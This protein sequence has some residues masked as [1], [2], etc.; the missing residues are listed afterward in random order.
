[1]HKLLLTTA[2]LAVMNTPG[3]AELLT[4]TITDD[5]ALVDTVSSA[6]GAISWTTSDTNF[7][8]ISG[9]ASGSPLLP[10][11]D[12][13]STALNVRDTA[14]G[15]HTLVIDIT[16]TGVSGNGPTESSFTANNLIGAAN[17][18]TTEETLANGSMLAT[19][20]FPV[21]TVSGHFGP[22]SVPFGAISSDEHTYT[23]TF[24]GAGSS[25]DTIQLNTNAPVATIP[26]TSTWAM[27][28]IGFGFLA[29]GALSRR[30]FNSLM[31]A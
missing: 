24:T 14:G 28:M 11:A 13:S 12:L 1:M 3:A 9:D 25:N 30:K 22:V 20:N 31:E 27:L 2:F 23:L 16:Q 4:V 10:F 7:V 17:I 21:G 8:D 15:T 6:T 18:D 5:G 26:E 19:H 29:W